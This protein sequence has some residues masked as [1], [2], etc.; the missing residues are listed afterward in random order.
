MPRLTRL[1]TPAFQQHFTAQVV[2]YMGSKQA[3]AAQL[4]SLIDRAVAGQRVTVT[5]AGSQESELQRLEKSEQ[6]RQLQ[7]YQAE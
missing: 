7:L 5:R 6:S 1:L 4:K 2:Y 3:S